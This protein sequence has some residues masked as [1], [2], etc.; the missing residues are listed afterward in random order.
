MDGPLDDADITDKAQWRNRIIYDLTFFI[1]LGVL[2][3][4]VVTGIILDTFGELREEVNDRK[5]KLENET[6]ISGIARDKIEEMSQ[7]VE[8][9]VVNEKDQNVWNYLFFIIYV[10]NKDE[11]ELNGVESFVKEC[12]D[13]EDTSWFPQKTSWR[14]EYAELTM[15]DDKGPEEIIQ[16]QVSRLAEL[17]ETMKGAIKTI[18]S[19]G[20]HQE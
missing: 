14:I 3:F 2:L 16:E 6:F 19:T 20:G 5:D 15:E 17:E 7:E 1:I 12:I 10:K 18:M 4:D 9:D 8:F 11:G 13:N